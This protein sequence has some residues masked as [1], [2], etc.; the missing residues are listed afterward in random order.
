M[1]EPIVFKRSGS[2]AF[3]GMVRNVLPS[4][5]A[6]AMLLG[7]ARAFGVQMSSEFLMMGIVVAVIAPIVIQMPPMPSEQLIASRWPTVAGLLIRWVALLA[8]LLAVGY[9]AKVSAN[10]SRLVVLTWAVTTPAILVVMTVA[11]DEFI[12]RFM[13]DPANA[14]SA[15]F[16]GYNEASVALDERL[17][18]HPELGVKV[19]GFFDDRNVD[20]L[21]AHG[22]SRMRGGLASMAGYIRENAID[23]I[24]ISLPMRNVQRVSNLLDDLQDTTASI[25]YVPD[26][27]VF[28]LIQSRSGEILG[29]PVV[30]LCETPFHGYRGVLKRFMD[31]ALA[32]GAVILLAPLLA[33]IALLIKLGSPGPVIFRQRRYG[34]DGSEIVVNK[35][36]TMTVMEDG[37][38]IRQ[39]TP[40]DQRITSLGRILR[41]YSLD[42][43]P[44]LFNVL[45]GSMSLVGPRPHAVAHNE[46]YRRLIKGYMIR[47]K[48][49]P[50]MTGLAQ[51]KGYRGETPRVEE[52]QARIRYDLEYLRRWTPLLDIKIILQTTVMLLGDR[53]AY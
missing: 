43:L 29:V 35:F 37:P 26:V 1:N 34:L 3:L 45:A 24:F 32:G 22:E 31:V 16:A 20:R 18:S 41:R 15:V 48:V 38:V 40:D 49:P 21:G 44:Q 17:H 8:I 25:Y 9:A 27:F 10:F 5:I 50:G 23:V 6:V 39:A 46:Q 33:L 42:E 30:A 47:H 51:V 19:V 14:R 53:K 7:L 11:L 36:R 52:M 13:F 4:V 2:L 12:R 28:D